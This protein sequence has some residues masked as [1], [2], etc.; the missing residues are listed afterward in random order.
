MSLEDQLKKIKVLVLDMDGVLTDGSIIINSEGVETKIFSVQDGAGLKM[1][2]RAGIEPVII[3]GRN[4]LVTKIRAKELN[5]K[6]V[7]MG[8]TSKKEAFEEIRRE[9]RVESEEICVMGD[10]LV[11][12]PLMLDSGVAVAVP[13]APEYVKAKANYVTKKRGGK[14]AVREVTDML[15]KVQGKWDNLTER[16]FNLFEGK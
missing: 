8:M 11:D 2:Q 10:D 12:L 15:I 13:D 9:F 6:R 3:S 16:Y 1:L 7:Y 4:S 14:G 5:I